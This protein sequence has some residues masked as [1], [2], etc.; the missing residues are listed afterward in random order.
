MSFQKMGMFYCLMF[1]QASTECPPYQKPPAL[2]ADA[3]LSSPLTRLP[4][5][6]AHTNLC[7]RII[8]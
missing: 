4:H 3:T 8:E 7:E 5:S 2:A 1:G 6:E